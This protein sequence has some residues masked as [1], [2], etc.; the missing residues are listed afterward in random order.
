MKS[1]DFSIDKKVYF[2]KIYMGSIVYTVHD[3]INALNISIYYRLKK[4]K[5]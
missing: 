4:S 2:Q 5:I 3:K 1:V